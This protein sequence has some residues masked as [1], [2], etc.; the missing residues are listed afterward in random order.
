MSLPH[1]KLSAFSWIPSLHRQEFHCRKV[2]FKPASTLVGGERG[3]SADGIRD[4]PTVIEK[5]V[6]NSRRTVH[7][8]RSSA[9]L[10]PSSDERKTRCGKVQRAMELKPITHDVNR[11]CGSRRILYLTCARLGNRTRRSADPAPSSPTFRVDYADES[12]TFQTPAALGVGSLRKDSRFQKISRNLK[13]QD[14]VLK[15]LR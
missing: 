8:A 1:R 13:P 2:I 9:A 15:S 10:L 6:V 4:R 7:D 11:G 14:S 5:I 12:I 3:Q